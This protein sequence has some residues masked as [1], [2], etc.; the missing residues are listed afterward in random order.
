MQPPPIRS[1]GFHLVTAVGVMDRDY[2]LIWRKADR[3]GVTI[4]RDM[5]GP[6]ARPCAPEQDELRREDFL[7]YFG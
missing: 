7:A 5:L 4:G 2:L 1:V 6:D 3:F